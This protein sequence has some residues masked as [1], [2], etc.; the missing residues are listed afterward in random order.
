MSSDNN[1]TV[2]I[3]TNTSILFSSSAATQLF[4]LPAV[5]TTSDTLN[6]TF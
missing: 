2:T 3:P 6:V 5:S 4:N 1:Y